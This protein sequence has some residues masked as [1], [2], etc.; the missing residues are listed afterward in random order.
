VAR[1]EGYRKEKPRNSFTPPYVE[2]SEG[3]SSERGGEKWGI[4]SFKGKEKEM[5]IQG[6]PS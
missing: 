4:E 1:E 2:R 3:K 6:I 5:V